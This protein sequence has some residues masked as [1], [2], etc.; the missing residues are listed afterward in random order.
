MNINELQ[1]EKLDLSDVKTLV[2][3]A[4]EEGWN[5]G[6]NDAEVYF[7]TDPDGF[8]GFYYKNELIAG[9]S[10]VSYHGAYGFMGF[11]IVKPV[12]RGQ[13]IGEKLWYLRRDTLLSR[14]HKNAAIGMDGVVAM[15][16]FYKKGGFEI[17]FKDV[18]YEK[19]GISFP[20]DKHITS[21]KDTDFQAI[22]DYDEKCFGFPRP[23]F[24]K[25]WL[26]LPR[27]KTFKY[28]EN[29]QLK[30]F[31]I[32]RK[33]N[34]G[35]KICPL[36]ADNLNVAEALYQACLNA[37]NGDLLYIDIPMSNVA[38]KTLIEKYDASYIFECA[39]MYY[40]NPPK[41]DM[42]KIFG[43]TTFELG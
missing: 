43:I 6:P 14:L 12:Y 15:Q 4:Q 41:V 40:G 24:L 9:G 34:T 3:W 21:I 29:D 42:D 28:V 22:L 35:Y 33:A 30:G 26:Q 32:V 13:G 27:N 16:P 39:R 19:K 23:Q 37:V 1:F 20:V 17:A 25:P 31:A 10:I 5:P 36:F 11:F 38:A 18:R 8:Y 7:A 2:T